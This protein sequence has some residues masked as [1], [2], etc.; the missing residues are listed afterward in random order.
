MKYSQEAL[1]DMAGKVDLLDYASHTVDF[2]KH[3]GVTY[4]AICPFHN[5]K[6]AS[7]A[8]KTDENYFLCFGCGKSGSIYQWIQYTEGLTFNQAVQKVANITNSDLHDYVESD[9]M[10]FYKLLNRLSK[11]RNNRSVDRH[12]LDIG[13]DYN[14]K[15]KDE[16]PQEWL[17][18]GISAE[19]LKKYEIRV[20]PMSNRIVYPVFSD[21][22]ELISVKG[23][24]R[25]RNY[26]DL[27]IMK[28]MNYHKLGGR[29]DYFQ[30]MQQA[31]Q[32]IKQSGEIIIFEG[33]KSVMKVD[34][35]GYHNTVSA[36]TSTLNEYQIELLVRMHIKNVVI[37]FDKDVSLKKI[38]ECTKLLKKF[39][40]V[41]VVYDRWGLLQ[42]KDSPCDQ[43]REIWNTLYERRFRI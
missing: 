30:G 4:Y 29:L 24:T 39:T 1:D 7:L 13:K 43:G 8:V 27:K 2:V 20:D 26:K 36:E 34:Q 42:D 6:T 9:S 14:Q 32:Y 18:E 33:I 25:F 28:Y 35:W 37:A 38:Q 3:S 41:Y 12:I 16:L 22:D 10:A 19:E 5:E 21:D 15:F 31:R 23:R 40:N 11:P 17:D